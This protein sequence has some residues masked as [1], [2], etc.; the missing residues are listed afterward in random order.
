MNE[1]RVDM[2]LT[3]PED[4]EK[5]MHWMQLIFKLNHTMPFT[6]EC[7]RQESVFLEHGTL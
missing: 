2:R 1:T 6:T 5:G 7:R 4:R 3:K